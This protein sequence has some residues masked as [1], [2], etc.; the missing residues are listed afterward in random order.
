[1]VSADAPNNAVDAGTQ[2]ELDRTLV[3]G[4]A[5]TGGVKWITQ[6]V[7]WASTLLI[8]RIL[9]P[10]DY[11]LVGI[12][13]LY[14]SLV[15][16]VNEFGL[17][18]AIV[19]HRDLRA[20]VIAQ[21]G[22]LSTLIGVGLAVVSLAG[23]P[24]TA[25][26]FEAPDVS[27]VIAILS[28]SFVLRALQVVP[29]ALLNRDLKFK[30]LAMI[31]GVE[32]VV[33]ALAT[34][35]GAIAGMG[36]WALVV[37]SLM[38]LGIATVLCVLM[39]PHAI[40]LPREWQ[41]LRASLRF[42][43]NMVVS[44]IAWFSFT[45]ADFVVVGRVLGKSVLG[46]YQFGWTLANIPVDRISS[47]AVRVTPAVFA[48]VQNDQAALKRY[49]FGLT[50]GLALITFPASIG[51]ALVA[52]EFVF[53]VLGPQWEQ[54]ILPLQY[55]SIYG[56]LRSVTSLFP[57]ILAAT[58]QAGVS[59]RIN[60][61]AALVM[62][63]LFLAGSHWG[64]QGVA[65]MWLVGYP[66]VV[67]PMFAVHALRAVGGTVWEFLTTLVPAVVCTVCMAAAV[68]VARLLMAEAWSV[69]MRFVTLVFTGAVG[70]GLPIVVLYGGKLRTASG[71]LKGLRS[72]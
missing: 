13:T 10:D 12:A 26:F 69:T 28:L 22:G 59:A 41:D 18:A 38:S 60:V 62:P 6:G 58:G 27:P 19:Q 52:P 30:R 51:M 2:G 48:V 65:L 43:A 36:Y 57:S 8:A 20:G 56:A 46:A 55:L 4:I 45:N 23:S 31:D 40:A 9:T 35:G 1:M 15:Q 63:V 29:K 47:L 33:L 50:E 17:S 7:R 72:R 5:W 14:L 3:R 61:V 39:R 53:V 68:V 32:A 24:L 44:R 11:G 37:G 42:G 21:L 25:A 34:L 64:A 49:L 71:M 54:A 67:L 16:L 70:Y 66:F